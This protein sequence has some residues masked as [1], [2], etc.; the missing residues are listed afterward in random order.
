MALDLMI[1]FL[2]MCDYQV[3]ES[4]SVESWRKAIHIG[5]NRADALLSEAYPDVSGLYLKLKLL[6]AGVFSM[7]GVVLS[8]QQLWYG[9]QIIHDTAYVPIGS[10]RLLIGSTPDDP[11][12][13]IHKWHRMYRNLDDLPSYRAIFR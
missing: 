2:C 10:L 3:T 1:K 9:R 12:W 8:E 11:E 7:M 6:A 5:G 4:V 13:K